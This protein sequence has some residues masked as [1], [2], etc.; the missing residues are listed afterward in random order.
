MV[1]RNSTLSKAR[2]CTFALSALAAAALVACGGSSSDADDNGGPTTTLSGVVASGAP[3]GGASVRVIDSDAATTD[4]AAV[5]AA[6]DG[7]YTIDVSGLKAPFA[8]V[9][10]GTLDGAASASSPSC[11]PRTPVRPTPPTSPRSPTPSR[12]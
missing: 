1:A 6:A 2:L 11:L 9:A 5:T 3:L 7:S 12:R 4:P 10:T 8:V